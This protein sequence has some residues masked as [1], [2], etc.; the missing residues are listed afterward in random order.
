MILPKGFKPSAQQKKAFEVI[1]NSNKSCFIYGRA[2]TG[3]SSFIEY[4]KTKTK[5]NYICLSRNG[6]AAR[7]IGGSTIH[8]FFKFPPRTL[9]KDDDPTLILKINLKLIYIA[10][11]I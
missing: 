8:S 9:L 5:K 4:L 11:L 1:N 6:M 10:V 2:G 7:L 3:K